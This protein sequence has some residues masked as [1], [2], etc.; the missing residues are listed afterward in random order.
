MAA[1]VAAPA[2][3]SSTVRAMISAASWSRVT[4]P[5]WSCHKSR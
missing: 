1:N 4:P 3:I 2:F 5:N